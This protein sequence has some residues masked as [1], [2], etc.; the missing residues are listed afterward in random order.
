MA[1]IR[2]WVGYLRWQLGSTV[3]VDLSSQSLIP[4]A[5]GHLLSI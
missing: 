4:V 5:I 3:G 1:S 2:R